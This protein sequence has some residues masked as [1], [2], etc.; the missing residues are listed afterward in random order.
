MAEVIQWKSRQR[1]EQHS[2]KH[3]RALSV[4]TTEAY[5]RSA[6]YVIE[7]GTYFEYRDPKTGDWRIGYYDRGT[8]R[9]V[10]MS[11]DGLIIL[12]YFRCPERYVASILPGS[13]YA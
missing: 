2:R 7:H 1:L 11:D 13:T 8:E 5:D 10:G 6:R 4:P 9:F 3:G 12:T